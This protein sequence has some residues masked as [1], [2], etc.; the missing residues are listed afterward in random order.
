MYFALKQGPN[1]S[2]HR[3]W[4]PSNTHNLIECK[5]QGQ[6]KAMCWTRLCNGQVLGP[7]CVEG[8]MDQYVYREMIEEKV[9]P[10]L[11][12]SATMNQLYF[13]Q[14]STI[15]ELQQVV[16]EFC[17]VNECKDDKKKVCASARKRFVKMRE[18]RGGHFE[19]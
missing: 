2:I 18:T 11:R 3:F 10:L 8:T 6:K 5:T 13:M 19:H 1:K 7:F 15:Y 14:D 16:N 12:R 9:W 4:S 17:H